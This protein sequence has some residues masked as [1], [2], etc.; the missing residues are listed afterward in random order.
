MK[1]EEIVQGSA[2]WL[3]ARCG[4]I[5]ASRMADVLATLKRKEGE[6]AVR[7]NYKAE[8]VAERL[9]GSAADHYVSYW[10]ERGTELEP[11]AR[12]AYEMETGNMVDQAGFFVHPEIP[13]F[14]ASPDGLIGAAGGLELKAPKITTHIRY[15]LEGVIPEEYEPQMSSGMACTGREWWDFYSY[16]PEMPIHLQTFIRRLHRNPERMFTI[17]TAVRQFDEEIEALISKLG[18]CIETKQ[19]APAKEDPESITAED[20]AWAVRGFKD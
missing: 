3:Q 4:R 14:G 5:T 13:C 17:E 16:C 19:Q 15:M 1:T 20:V 9:T 2:E 12:A 6:A 7:A 8:L 11:L 10:M 18:G